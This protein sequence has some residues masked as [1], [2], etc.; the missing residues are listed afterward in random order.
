VRNQRRDGGLRQHLADG[1]RI[2]GVAKRPLS[3]PPRRAG[4]LGMDDTRRLDAF[5]IE[6]ASDASERS[7]AEEVVYHP[8]H[9]GRLSRVRLQSAVL[10]DDVPIGALLVPHSVAPVVEMPLPHAPGGVV[11]FGT[12]LLGED[13]DDRPHTG[14]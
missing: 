3:A 11:G 10:V 12:G 14:L 9:D 8:P 5:V 13:G 6:P 7:A 4:V 2:P 1:G